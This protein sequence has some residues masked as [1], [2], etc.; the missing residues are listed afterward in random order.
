MKVATYLEF[1]DNANDVVE[2][3]KDIFNAEVILKY[4]F[5]ERM[6][7][8]P[9]LVGKV[10]H[11][12]LKIGDLNLYLCDTGS[13]SAFPSMKLVTEIHDEGE[14]HII[15]DKLAHGGIIIRNFTKMSFGPIIADVEDKFGIKWNI[16]IC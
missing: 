9:S 13:D 14:A 3:Y 7:D 15:F 16:V 8:E 5:D 1:K 12:E 10:F 4:L 6:T 2:A 11:A